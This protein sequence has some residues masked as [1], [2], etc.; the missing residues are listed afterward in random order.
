L[1]TL[2]LGEYIGFVGVLGMIFIQIGV[3]IIST[4]DGNKQPN[5]EEN[6]AKEKK[7]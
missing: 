3:L 5:N 6:D 1:G 7:E 4:E 2:L